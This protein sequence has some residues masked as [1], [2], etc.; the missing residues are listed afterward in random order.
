MACNALSTVV[1]SEEEIITI[2]TAVKGLVNQYRDEKVAIIGGVRTIESGIYD[3]G[4]EKHVF[5]I[6]QP[7]SALVEKGVIE[8]AAVEGEIRKILDP[9]Q[10]VRKIIMA[11]THYPVLIPV[12]AKLYPDIE[13]IDPVSE[14]L[15]DL[16]K[17]LSGENTS[18]FFTSGDMQEMLGS[19]QKCWDLNLIDVHCVDF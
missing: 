7:L 5:G 13:F 19:V 11:C 14:L 3:L 16:P 9:I 12:F 17:E 2:A 8:G 10:D 4:F 15:K 18:K 6:A 1:E